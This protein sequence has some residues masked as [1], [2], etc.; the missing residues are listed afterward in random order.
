MPSS[1]TPSQ[2]LFRA[3]NRGEQSPTARIEH[4]NIQLVFDICQDVRDE[5][6]ARECIGLAAELEISQA[7][8][9]RLI[10]L[11]RAGGAVI[12]LVDYKRRRVVGCSMTNT[13]PNDRA[14]LEDIDLHNRAKRRGGNEILK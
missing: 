4:D 5:L 11:L 13:P 7:T 12:S 8:A 2:P 3:A 14:R 9:D 1:Q 10:K 6:N